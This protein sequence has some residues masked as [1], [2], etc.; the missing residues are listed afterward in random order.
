MRPL[1][2]ARIGGALYLVIIIA[3]IVGPLLTT[4]QLI[5]AGDADTTAQNI[6]AS[7][8][9]WRLGIAANVLMQLCDVP[10]MLILFLLLSPVNWNVALLA[11]LFN[12][13]QTAT[14]VANQLTLVAAQLLSVEQPAL[15]DVAI[16]AYSY[17]E[18]LGL[19]F[20]GF[21]LL[22]VGYLIRHSGYLPWLIGLLVQIA[23]VSYVVNSFL[24]LVV[25]DLANIALLVPAFVAELSLAL[26]LLVKG[27]DAPTWELLARGT[28]AT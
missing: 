15:T 14:L 18:A 13:V 7:P 28:E 20:F 6:S 4:G 3:G 1:G 10:V 26:W 9:L 16:Q 12:I 24:L 23:G 25:P 21:T 5:V 17:G 19:V 8:E 27:V 22:G 2:Y 11:L